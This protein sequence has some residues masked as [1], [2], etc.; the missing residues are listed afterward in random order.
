MKEQTLAN[1]K[2]TCGRQCQLL[3]SLCQ[4]TF[5]VIWLIAWSLCYVTCRVTAAHDHS[6]FTGQRRLPRL[7]AKSAPL[8]GAHGHGQTTVMIHH[9]APRRYTR[10]A[11]PPNEWLTNLGT[12]GQRNSLLLLADVQPAK[13]TVRYGHRSA[14]FCA[15][16]I[17]S[18]I[19]D[20]KFF[21]GKRDLS[22]T[23]P[24]EMISWIF[25]A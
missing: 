11:V 3:L 5:S 16:V 14:V 9:P 25:P 13:D 12:T 15:G 19:F 21:L 22:V 17:L 10:S 2:C 1:W 4:L 8:S 6:A 23:F 7:H 24:T 20:R 18:N